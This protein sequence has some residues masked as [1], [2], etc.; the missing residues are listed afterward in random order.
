ME[1]NVRVFTSFVRNLSR[2]GKKEFFPKQ[3]ILLGLKMECFVRVSRI[4]LDLSG[5]AKN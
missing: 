1:R 5:Y 3:T 2:Y 4:F